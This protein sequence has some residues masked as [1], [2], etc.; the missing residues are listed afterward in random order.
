MTSSAA[1]P[2]EA[3]HQ[4]GTS[5]QTDATYPDVVGG[6]TARDDGFNRNGFETAFKSPSLADLDCAER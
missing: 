1:A 6:A 2:R 3:M 5:S 4:Q